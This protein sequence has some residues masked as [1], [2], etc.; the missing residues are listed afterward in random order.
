VVDC[1]PMITVAAM[2]GEHGPAVLDIYRLGIATGNA[3]FE[4]EPPS[5]DRFD[6]RHRADHRFVA[7]DG[8]RVV[9]WVACS[10]VSDRRVYAGVVEHSVYVHPDARGRGVGRRLLDT[11]IASTEAAGIWTIQSGIFPENTASVALHTA[12]GFRVIGTRE[13]IGRHHGVWRDVVLLERRS[14]VIG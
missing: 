9:G 14:P 13:K 6:A 4:T 10:T 8:D 5:W 7:L 1:G 11:V 2:T 12:A 3:T